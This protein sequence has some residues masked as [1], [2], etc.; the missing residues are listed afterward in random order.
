[1][2]D[3]HINIIQS[4]KPPLVAV[5]VGAICAH[6]VGSKPQFINALQQVDKEHD[7]VV[8]MFGEIDCRIHFHYQHLKTGKSMMELVYDTAIRYLDSIQ[9]ILTG[10]KYA[11]YLVVPAG[12]WA[13][14][15]G[16]FR[17]YPYS[18][19]Y[20]RI[21]SYSM[22]HDMVMIE[23]INRKIRYIDLWPYILDVESQ[24]A[25]SIYRCDEV[26]LGQRAI[27][28]LEREIPKGL[29]I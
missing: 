29:G 23:C 2:G 17:G 28:I 18:T 25:H 16:P 11:V 1:M 5:G 7:Y 13:D 3:S 15:C 19:Q 20:D 12:C 21:N 24:F 26:H 27:P 8:P 22:F 6:N 14:T 10:Y 4:C 9:R